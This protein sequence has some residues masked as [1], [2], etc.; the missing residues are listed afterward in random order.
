MLLRTR[1]FRQLVALALIPSCIIALAACFLLFRAIDQT[2]RWLAASSPDRTINALRVVETRL[3]DAAQEIV[4]VIDSDNLSNTNS[5]F[6]WFVVAKDGEIIISK[7]YIDLP[8]GI[9]SIISHSLKKA[10]PIREI[11]GQNIAIG[12][13]VFKNGRLIAGGFILG[14]EYLSGFEATSASLSESRGYKNILPAFLLFIVVAGAFVLTVVIIVAYFLS[15]RLSSSITTPLEK[16]AG[17]SN[18]IAEGKRYDKIAVTGTDEVVALAETLNRMTDDLEQSRQRLMAAERVAAWQEFARRMAHELK[19]P[20]T[21]ISV[22]LY[23]IK[24]KLEG[25]GDYGRYAEPIEAIAA[26][27][28]HLERLAGDYASLAG[29]PEPKFVMFEFNGLVRKVVELFAAQL[30]EYRLENKIEGGAVEV[31]GDPDR[32]REVMVNLLKNAIEFAPGRGRIEIT[33]GR[34]E[35]RVFFSVA[36]DNNDISVS[37]DNLR[38]AKMPYFTTRK[39]GSGLGLA[40]SEKIIVDHRGSLTLGLKDGMTEARFEIPDGQSAQEIGQ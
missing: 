35:N 19:N 13:S 18:T 32:L 28:S 34:K 38:V 4:M 40:I 20:L 22:S 31:K 24:K 15:R 12:S 10:G 17:F 25:S 2:S 21:P 3:Q 14:R 11:T 30:E 39:G 8:R 5:I 7:A 26:E 6:D 16:L 33:A 36:N 37:A 9:D 1:I 29:L 23:R 27:V